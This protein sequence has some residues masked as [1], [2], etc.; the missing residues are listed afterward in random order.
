[1]AS[2]RALDLEHAATDLGAWIA[3]PWRA[4]TRLSLKRAGDPAIVTALA[5]APRT[6]S[7]AYLDLTYLAIDGA[8]L[9]ELARAL[10]GVREL[11]LRQCG[12]RADAADALASAPLP[13]LLRLDLRNNLFTD[14]DRAK[15]VERFGDRV[16]T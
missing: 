8:R 13:S 2:L 7:L 1:V 9:A 15:L 6:A 5:T 14:A 10:T 16:L 11:L 3:I 4:L 12:L